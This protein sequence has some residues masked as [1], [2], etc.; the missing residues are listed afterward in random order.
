[1]FGQM[2]GPS[3]SFYLLPETFEEWLSFGA[4]SLILWGAT[5]VFLLALYQDFSKI[6]RPLIVLS[7]AMFMGGLWLTLATYKHQRERTQKF[8]KKE[9]EG[10]G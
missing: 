8:L 3:R 5:G 6:N 1:M 9:K 4:A 10:D 7:A 2:K